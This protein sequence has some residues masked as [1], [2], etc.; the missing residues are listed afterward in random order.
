MLYGK[1]TAVKWEKPGCGNPR[2]E[3][4]RDPD[5]NDEHALIGELE[6]L[7]YTFI[8]HLKAKY[9]TNK[10]AK[11][12]FATYGGRIRISTKGENGTKASGA[13][14]MPSSG[15]MI[16]NPYFESKRKGV[17]SS[18]T[19]MDSR[20]RMYTRLLHE[21]AHSTPPLGH[22]QEFYRAQRFF[23]RVASTD[24]GWRLDVNCRVCCRTDGPCTKA[25]C[26][27]CNWTEDPSSCDAETLG[28]GNCSG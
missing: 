16:M 5:N 1:F 26:P 11:N 23:L 8:S 25:V 4:W 15:C 27:D 3:N 14:F 21:L 20:P 9:P 13:S 2:T 24:L 19:G 17:Q 22:H 12:L 10:Y 6:A 18:A 7:A 28:L